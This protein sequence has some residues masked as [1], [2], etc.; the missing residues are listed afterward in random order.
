M[1]DVVHKVEAHGDGAGKECV[2]AEFGQGEQSVVDPGLGEGVEDVVGGFGVGVRGV[3]P[4]VGD[5][6]LDAP[7]AEVTTV[8]SGRRGESTMLDGHVRK[9]VGEVPARAG[10]R[11]GQVGGLN[12]IDEVDRCEHGDA[13]FI[14]RHMRMICTCL[15]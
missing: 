7:V 13:V 8:A 15:S 3:V 14:N 6:G 2:V 10:G 12:R 1:H 11:A 5:D 4:N 9:E